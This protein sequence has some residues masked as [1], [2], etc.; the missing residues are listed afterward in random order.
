MLHI[1][2]IMT[3]E[4]WKFRVDMQLIAEIGLDSDDLEDYLW[5][6]DYISGLSP[7]NA[8]AEFLKE[9]RRG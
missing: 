9:M 1:K 3:F 4:Q 2:R 7:S 5:Y 6:D 8:V